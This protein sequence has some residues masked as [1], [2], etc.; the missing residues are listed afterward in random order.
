MAGVIS[1]GPKR[2]RNKATEKAG[3]A[4]VATST[5]ERGDIHEIY[6]RPG[7]QLRRAYQILMSLAEEECARLDLTP[8]QQTCIGVL[9]RCG[10]L[11]QN[12][13]A[14]AMGMDRAT[15]GQLLRR[16]ESKGW[17]ERKPDIHDLRR[18]LVVL[19][20]SGAALVSQAD[21]VAERV[22][23][24]LLEGL[25]PE[26]A[27]TWLK[28]TSKLTKAGEPYCGTVLQAPEVQQARREG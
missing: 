3:A 13:L 21:A 15:M 9:A 14:R 4:P 7:F 11:D 6:A 25:T 10:G 18:K 2:G 1:T 24:R 12:T 22:G 8:H 5:T 27:E 23:E 26:E 28:L 20:Q 16:L 19:T 17:I